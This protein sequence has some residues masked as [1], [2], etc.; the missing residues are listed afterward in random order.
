VFTLSV[1]A[2][3]DTLPDLVLSPRNSPCQG[4]EATHRVAS[5]TLK[6][7][8]AVRL[9]ATSDALAV[10]VIDGLGVVWASTGGES[11][12]KSNE[13]EKIALSAT[14]LFLAVPKLRIDHPDR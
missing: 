3:L 12:A 14:L 6:L 8:L 7:I 4:P 11:H 2:K 9:I 10:R 13:K 1:S 5:E